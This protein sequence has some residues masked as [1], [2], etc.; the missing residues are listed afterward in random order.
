MTGST[1]FATDAQRRAFFAR[2]R[3]PRRRWYLPLRGPGSRARRNRARLLAGAAAL[4]SLGVL[5]L[6]RSK[7]AG[8]ATLL[9]PSGLVGYTAKIGGQ[10][11]SIWA[12]VYSRPPQDR[13]A[14]WA[15][16]PW[17][18][19][20]LFGSTRKIHGVPPLA[21]LSVAVRRGAAR[22]LANAAERF[23]LWRLFGRQGETLQQIDDLARLAKVRVGK[24]IGR[25]QRRV[26][27]AVLQAVDRPLA[28]LEQEVLRWNRRA[29]RWLLAR[30]TGAPVRPRKVSLMHR[31][32]RG[33]E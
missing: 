29:R 3:D 31:Q 25:L 28:R 9:R 21:K 32:M 17:V 4:G 1:R 22:R 6:A 11:R 27:P 30:H 19:P 15:S 20:K 16:V 14:F 33:G 13:E 26:A 23:S 5:A 7:R 18:G 2:A 8:L 10:P 12:W 24:Q